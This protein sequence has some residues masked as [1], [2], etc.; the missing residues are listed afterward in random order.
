M[1]KSTP[2]SICPGDN[3]LL[4]G[5]IMW[6]TEADTLMTLRGLKLY[7]II[8]VMISTAGFQAQTAS[9]ES[10][11]T[12]FTIWEAYIIMADLAASRPKNLCYLYIIMRDNAIAK[13]GEIL[14]T[15]IINGKIRKSRRYQSN[16]RHWLWI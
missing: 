10:S 7:R 6:L 3:R 9:K 8:C 13:N 16:C 2:E 12:L 4:R 14:I 5:Y 15:G 1:K 11:K